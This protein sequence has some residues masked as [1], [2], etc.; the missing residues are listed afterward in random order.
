MRMRA[1]E[2]IFLEIPCFKPVNLKKNTSVLHR[3]QRTTEN[4]AFTSQGIFCRENQ[5]LTEFFVVDFWW[6]IQSPVALQTF[7]TCKFQ[8]EEDVLHPTLPFK[9]FLLE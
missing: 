7:D 1:C 9:I 8:G 2:I 5:E 4:S 3:C 6:V